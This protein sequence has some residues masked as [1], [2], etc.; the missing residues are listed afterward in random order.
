LINQLKEHLIEAYCK[1]KNNHPTLP[2]LI[3]GKPLA[4]ENLGV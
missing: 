1:I 2:Y 4:I 3:H